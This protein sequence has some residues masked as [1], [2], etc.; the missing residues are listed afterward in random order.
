MLAVSCTFHSNS[1]NFLIRDLS[2]C[3]RFILA[4]P[5]FLPN[6]FNFHSSSQLFLSRLLALT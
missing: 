6:S 2:Y 1:F 3:E 4:F 5:I